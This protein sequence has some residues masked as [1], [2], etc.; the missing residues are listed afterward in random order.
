VET[1]RRNGQNLWV[2]QTYQERDQ[3]FELQSLNL[4]LNF[5]DLYE[6]VNLEL[7]AIPANT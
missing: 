2:L 4:T 7:V 3:T 6:D 5:T 1:F